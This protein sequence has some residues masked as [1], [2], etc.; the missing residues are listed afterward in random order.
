MKIEYL[1][2]GFIIIVCTVAL[3]TPPDTKPICAQLKNTKTKGWYLDGEF[4]ANRVTWP[5][6]A[7]D[8][9]KKRLLRRKIIGY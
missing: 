9:E 8:V 4:T 2:L 3:L 1:L 5:V 6:R 7:E